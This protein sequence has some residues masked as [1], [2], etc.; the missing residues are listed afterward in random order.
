M[1]FSFLV[2][3]LFIYHANHLIHDVPEQVTVET[4]IAALVER[5]AAKTKANPAVHPAAVAP[6]RS[7]HTES[8]LIQPPLVRTGANLVARSATVAHSHSKSTELL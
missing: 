6:S 8:A 2:V 7:E 4:V 1:T 5:M 3:S